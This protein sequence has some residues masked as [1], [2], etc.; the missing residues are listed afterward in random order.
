MVA[1]GPDEDEERVRLN[2]L[3]HEALWA[4]SHNST[5]VDVID[6]LIAHLHPQTTLRFPGRW[7]HILAEHGA[8]LD[9]ITEHR[10]DDAAAIATEHMTKAREIRLQLYAGTLGDRVIDRGA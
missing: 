6:R 2:R 4:A 5:L 10:A 3:F 1:A 7:E 8:L 9:A